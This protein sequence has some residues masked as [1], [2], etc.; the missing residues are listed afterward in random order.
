MTFID[1]SYLRTIHVGLKLGAVHKDNVSA[2]PIG[3]IGLYE[4][5]L[6]PASNLN[7]R[8]KFLD[9]FS[10]WASLK[11]EVSSGFVVSLLEG[12]TE[13]Q[14]TNYIAQNSKWFNSPVTGKYILYHERLRTF[15]LQKVSQNRLE[16]CNEGIIQQ[17]QLALQF[18][19]GDEWERYALEYLSAHLLSKAMDIKDGGALKTLAYD[20]AHWSRQVEI[21]TS[22]EWSKRMLNDMMLWASKYDDDEVIECALNKVDLYHL[23]QNDA[24][25]IVELVVLNDIDTALKRIESF[26]E[27]DK[28]GLQRKFILYML[29]FMELTLFESKDKS[30]R[31]EALEKLLKHLDDNL[32]VDYSVLNWNEFFPSNLL[33]Q[34]ATEWAEI[35][36]DYLVVYK[37]TSYF[38]LDGI[39]EKG[40][41]TK[42]QLSV[43]IE[44]A[45]GDSD[46]DQLLLAK[47][48][49][50]LGQLELALETARG[51][52]HKWWS[53]YA[54]KS[55]SD[56][57][58]KQGFL[59]SAL[60]TARG[61][62]DEKDR[63]EALSTISRELSIKFQLEAAA[64]VMQEALETACGINDEQARSEALSTISVELAK[65]GQLELALE[66]ARDISNMWY[67]TKALLTI[68]RELSR[69]CQFEAAASV[70]QEARETACGIINQR[71]KSIAI[72][73]ISSEL[74]EQ[75]KIDAAASVMQ[76]A[77][78]LA[79]GIN[80]ERGKSEALG[81]ISSELAKQGRVE[82]ALACVRDIYWETKRV[83]V[84][85]EISS[86]LAKKGMLEGAESAMREA[87]KCTKDIIN[88]DHKSDELKDI[89]GELAKQGKLEEALV[90][91]RGITRE[92]VKSDT[93]IKISAE[94]AKQGKLEEASSAMQEAL[95]FTMG[96]SGEN[97]SAAL[98]NLSSELIEQGKLRAAATV[99]QEGLALTR[100]MKNEYVKGIAL[101]YISNELALRGMFVL[102]L[103]CARGVKDELGKT[104]ALKKIF[105]ELIKR[106]MLDEASSV[107]REAFVF[108][109][110]IS[111][112]YQKEKALL[113]ISSELAKHVNF[114]EILDCV[115]SIVD[116]YDRSNVLQ[117]ISS[118]FAKLRRLESA[119][120]FIEEA[121]DCACSGLL[122]RNDEDRKA[123]ALRNISVELAKQ[124]KI[125]K[126]LACARG[127]FNDDS[128]INYPIAGSTKP[129]ALSVISGELRRQGKV[130]DA[131]SIMMEATTCARS[132]CN[133][134]IKNIALIGVSKEL[135]KQGKLEE[136]LACV[137][138]IEDED[139]KGIAL[140]DISIEIAKQGKTDK[141][142]ECA[143][144]INNV[145]SKSHALANASEE[146]ARQGNFNEAISCAMSIQDEHWKNF[147]LGN[148]SIEIAKR[149]MIEEAE[150]VTCRIINEKIRTAS[151]NKMAE[152]IY[153]IKGYF[154]SIKA[155]QKLSNVGSKVAIK[156]TIIR[157]VN[158]ATI[159]KKIA[160]D[161]FKDHY[162]SIT[163]LERTIQVFCLNE[164]FFLELNDEKIDRYNRT[165]NIQWAID[166][167][168]AINSN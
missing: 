49:A 77:L 98:M 33:F 111:A 164:L 26:A 113:S 35:G 27:N 50:K 55:V 83:E 64:S 145:T 58:A 25:R 148:I 158:A 86:Y 91:A 101:N 7:E 57:L 54:F 123:I 22:F 6:S 89:S 73:D 32:P 155:L 3:L 114:E 16:K 24:P 104:T 23:E 156:V 69:K 95:A 133:I 151:L 149:G 138:D 42:F 10:V 85:R 131:A 152:K 129:I 37:R 99:M 112:E 11:T 163:T 68:S 93:L 146:I 125:E 45:R 165:L 12:W 108:V 9:F 102:A 43:L 118:E 162:Q 13:D 115:R 124:R 168:R 127:I 28:E 18:K 65:H 153:E 31:V 62:N 92:H 147:A 46:R 157:L 21:S 53:N 36:L 76:E 126:A 74:A 90:C 142:L 103:A 137:W 15:V 120:Y 121:Y 150:N 87:L 29:C 56:E 51:I 134:E 80:D 140:K 52:S 82:D 61:I 75:G 154:T 96:I 63:S 107:M 38:E 130:D 105:S 94:Q 2:L 34:M 60:E 97:R 110:G 47:K 30:H 40:P 139:T 109:R 5:A 166:I 144:D 66:T 20:T 4:D 116:V 67:K 79:Q 84:I 143:R 19:V 1:P 160:S 135:A 122:G 44:A 161:V 141:A 159:D 59:E 132:I 106:G 48:L 117:V 8:K 14:V 39:L 167:K 17:S 41:Y 136:A 128:K 81:Y 119:A 71:Y 78:T 70:M 88:E 100:G 72:T